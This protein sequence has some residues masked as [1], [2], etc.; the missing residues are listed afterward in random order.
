[1]AVH[2]GNGMKYRNDIP[3]KRVTEDGVVDST[4]SVYEMWLA[5]RIVFLVSVDNDDPELRIQIGK[6]NA[7]VTDKWHTSVGQAVK[8]L[9][10]VPSSDESEVPDGLHEHIDGTSVQAY[11]YPRVAL[12]LAHMYVSK[13]D[14]TQTT[15]TDGDAPQL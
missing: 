9:H 15:P 2:N 7:D 5:D 13:A 1:M 11:V 3:S 6:P 10:T 14:G 4:R 8:G 12:I